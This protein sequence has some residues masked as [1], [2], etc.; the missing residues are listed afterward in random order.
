M[1][2]F[3]QLP[4]DGAGVPIFPGPR[5]YFQFSVDLYSED[6]ESATAVGGLAFDVV[7]PPYAEE[8]IAEISP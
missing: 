2:D 4:I 7:S 5:R 3:N 6:F 8:L 1:V